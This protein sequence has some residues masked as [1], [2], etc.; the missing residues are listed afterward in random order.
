[1]EEHHSQIGKGDDEDRFGKVAASPNL[2]NLP[3]RSIKRPAG[4]YG[5]QIFHRILIDLSW[6]SSRLEGNTYSLLE[7]ERLLQSGQGAE[8][9]DLRD[10]QMLLNHKAAIEFLIESAEQDLGIDRY[11]ILN[12]HALLSDN[13]IPHTACGRLRQNPVGIGGSTYTPLAI[14]Q[15]INECFQQVV[16]LAKAIQD[17]F[18]QAFFLMVHLPYLQAFEDVNKRVSRLAANLPLLRNNLCPLSFADVPEKIY[19]NGLL[20]IYEYNQIELYRDLFLWSYERSCSLYAVTRNV[21]G[22]P[23][24]FRLRLRDQIKELVAAVV[25]QQLDRTEAIRLIQQTA[26]ERIQPS[27]Q[28]QFI[29]AVETELMALHMGNIARYRLRL[30]EYERWQKSWLKKTS[31]P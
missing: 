25:R 27:D 10:T 18:E 7:T 3:A 9:R 22:E 24:P 12:I 30:D 23:D 21:L 20:G 5:R 4:T 29:Q 16:D 14:P 28:A 19:I 26:K 2:Q 1:M 15:L 6:N 13:L 31:Q 8:G 17:P 11:I